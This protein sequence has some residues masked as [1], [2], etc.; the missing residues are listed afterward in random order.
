MT[1][2]A[3]HSRQARARRSRSGLGRRVGARGH[4][5]VRPRPRATARARSTRSTR[6]RRRRRARCTSATCS[7]SRT[8]TSSRA[9]SACAAGTCSTRW[10]G[11]T[12]ACPPSA[13]CRT[14]TACGAT[15]RCPTTPTS[16][17]PSRAATTRARKA[18]DQ[19]P[20]SRRNFI[21]LC[22]R[23]TVEDEQQFEAL[24]RQLG[25]SRRLDADLP[26]HLRRDDPHVAARVPAQPRARRGVPGARADA[27][28]HRLP[29]RRRP[30]R[31]RGPRAGRRLPPRGLPPP[32]RR[33]DRD[34][35]D[36]APSCSPRASRS[37]RTPTTSATS[38]CS[39]RR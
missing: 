7:P 28:G 22:E 39:A 32:R 6:P 11:T 2:H 15:P 35:D 9:T 16:C 12:T 5:P 25:L 34:R 18:A 8:P 38:R 14:T 10:A 24:F 13:A 26:H 31:A 4:L 17:R 19:M 30:G 23:L 36:A 3:A 29:L 20:I 37:S 27:V 1:D 33:H 21:E